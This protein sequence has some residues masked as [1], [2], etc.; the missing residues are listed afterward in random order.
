[1]RISDFPES[2][3]TLGKPASMTDEECKS[4]PVWSNGKQCIS[5]WKPSFK[6]RISILLFGKVWVSVLSGKTQPPISIW[7]EKNTFESK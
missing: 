1:M 7:A 6:E 2:N 3:K 4:L 5:C